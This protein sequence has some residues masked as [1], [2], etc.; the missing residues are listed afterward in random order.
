MPSYNPSVTFGDSSPYTGE[1][2]VSVLIQMLVLKLM[3]LKSKSPRPSLGKYSAI[4]TLWIT[5]MTYFSES[6]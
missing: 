6:V 2:S 4:D 3:T 1:P 5:E